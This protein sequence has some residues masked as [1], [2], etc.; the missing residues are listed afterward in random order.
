MLTKN[1]QYITE[2]GRAALD[3][4]S[5]TRG[6]GIRKAGQ[7]L[8]ELLKNE[9]RELNLDGTRGTDSI[10]YTLERR[11]GKTTAVIE[12]A[13]EMGIPIVVDAQHKTYLESKLKE[14]R[15][16]NKVKLITLQDLEHR[17]DGRRDM[18]HTVLVDQ[19]TD[20][21]KSKKSTKPFSLRRRNKY[22]R[23]TVTKE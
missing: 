5:R 11:I 13:A 22:Y 9:F 4:I 12:L 3:E 17:M 19:P 6:S 21:K 23:H 16:Q 1:R 14:M 8:Y 15:I 10:I 2:E 20:A 18:P 7:E